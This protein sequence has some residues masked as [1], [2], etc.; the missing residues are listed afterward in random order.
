MPIF[1][2]PN[3]FSVHRPSGHLYGNE[4]SREFFYDSLSIVHCIASNGKMIY[5]LEGMYEE[6]AVA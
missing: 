6:T 4:H 5:E 1:S 3:N 2:L